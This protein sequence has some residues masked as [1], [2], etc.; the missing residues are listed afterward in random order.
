MA[1][2][3]NLDRHGNIMSAEDRVW[4]FKLRDRLWHSDSSFRPA[5]AKVLAALGAHHSV[6]GCQH[7]VCRHA[8]RL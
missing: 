3:S 6:L 1:D 4:F 5:P 8:G 2:F 7:R